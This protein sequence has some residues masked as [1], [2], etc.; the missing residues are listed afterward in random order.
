MN[1]TTIKTLDAP[2]SLTPL[3]QCLLNGLTTILRDEW[4][5]APGT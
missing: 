2:A 1:V 3:E 5:A 4:E